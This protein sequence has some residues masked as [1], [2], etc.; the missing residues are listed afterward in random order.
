MAQEKAGYVNSESP[1]MTALAESG[2]T[3]KAECCQ[4]SLFNLKFCTT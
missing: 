3:E 2:T 4:E 1:Q